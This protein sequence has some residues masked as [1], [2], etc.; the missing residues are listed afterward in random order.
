MLFIFK[1]FEASSCTQENVYGKK[2]EGKF[3]TNGYRARTV[4]AKG[5]TEGQSRGLSRHLRLS[6]SFAINFANLYHAR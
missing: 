2:A 4:E 3:F 5:R 6:T 1:I